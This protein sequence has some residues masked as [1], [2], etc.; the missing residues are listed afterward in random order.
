MAHVDSL[1]TGRRDTDEIEVTPEMIEA[2][3]DALIR[4]LGGAVSVFWEPDE[5]A[6]LVYRAMQS[7][8]VSP[9]LRL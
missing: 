8:S 2:G 6:I 4:V 7:E 9:A 1:A 3:V 5:L